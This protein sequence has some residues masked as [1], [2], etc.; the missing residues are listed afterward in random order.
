MDF[1]ANNT[2]LWSPIVQ[3]GIIA[4]LILLSNILRRKIPLVKNTLMPTAVLAGFILLILRTFNL[5]PVTVEFLEIITYHALALGF[6]SLS[7]RVPEKHAD[8]SAMIGSKSGALI[9]STY[10][11]QAT[12]GLAVSLTLAYT[13]MPKFF[14][15]SG[16]LLA[17]AYGQGPGQANNIGGS[18]EA[19]GML[20]GRSFGLTLAA[21]GYLCACIVGVIYL[22]VLNKKKN[23]SRVHD[24]D[25]VSGSV[26]IDTFQDKNEIPVAE[27]ID[28]LS[29]QV[30]L[31]FVVYLATFLFTWGITSL[32]GAIAPGFAKT[33]SDLLWGFNFIVGSMLAIVCRCVINGLRKS[34]IM[35]R[36]YQNNYLLSRIS[37]LAFDVMIV[38]G[39]AS[40][41]L[42]DLSGNWIPF[43][44]M[45]LLGGIATFVYLLFMCKK[46]YPGYVYEGFLSMFGMLTGTISSGVLLLREIDPDMKTPASNN[47]IT[48]SSFGIAFG[49]PVLLVVGFAATSEI[50]AWISLG[51]I[52][53]Y[54]AT[55]LFFI[56]KIGNKKKK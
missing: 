45:A 53:A 32:L 14:K 1:S 34:R 33:V 42:K 55:L 51:L 5:V 50:N 21:A 25:D 35:N 8:D 23:V 52:L 37:G 2:S 10:L 17:M 24:K 22:N 30:A 18:Y 6:I 16:I 28:K 12:V 7:L 41:E 48:G 29:V 38:A 15:A 54:L 56:L 39:I 9:V 46:L 3:I 40:I 4:G 26:T 36:Q 13:V 20:G 27:S 31:V 11:V 47:L 44:L 43:I 19:Q 49:F